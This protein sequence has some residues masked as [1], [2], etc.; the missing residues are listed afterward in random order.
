[1][2]G[3]L[4]LKVEQICASVASGKMMHIL[5]NGCE[6]DSNIGNKPR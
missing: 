1:M 4:K 6:N 3:N 5:K 2:R